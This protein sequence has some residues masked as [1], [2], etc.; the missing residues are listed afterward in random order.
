MKRKSTNVGKTSVKRRRKSLTVK[1]EKAVKA[2]AQKVTTKTEETKY[3]TY[4]TFTNPSTIQLTSYNIFYHGVS[5][6]S[7]N[8]QFIGD[9]LRWQGLK[10]K[11]ELTN[12]SGSRGWVDNPISV[13]LL[14]LSTPVYKTTTNLSVAD[15]ARPDVDQGLYTWLAGKETK[16]HFKRKIKLPSGKTGDRKFVS[17]DLWVKGNKKLTYKDFGTNYDLK[18]RNYYV[19]VYAQDDTAGLSTPFAGQIVLNMINY[20]KDS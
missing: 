11:Y 15:I 19:V 7:G 4:R 20:F 18:Q 16:I 8:N 1:Q 5:Q 6:G 14:V 17:G 3:F 9:S 12:Y 2:I 13:F 10:V